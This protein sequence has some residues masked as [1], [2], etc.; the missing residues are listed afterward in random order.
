MD[1]KSHVEDERHEGYEVIH[2]TKVVLI[3]K[4]GF[5]RAE[6]LTT[7]WQVAELKDKLERLL[8]GQEITDDFHPW[9]AFVSF[10]YRC[11]PV[12]FSSLGGAVTH[13]VFM[14]SLPIV[15]FG[16]YRLLIR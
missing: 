9:Q 7:E 4:E 13:S 11:G 12:S 2:T 5:L 10:L 8:S 15:L 16:I 6:L 3:D 14:P 1:G